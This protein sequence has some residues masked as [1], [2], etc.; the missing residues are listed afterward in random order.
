[1]NYKNLAEKKLSL[2]SE[3]FLKLRLKSQRSYFF[4]KNHKLTKFFS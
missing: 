2:S 4:Y 1:M 3:R